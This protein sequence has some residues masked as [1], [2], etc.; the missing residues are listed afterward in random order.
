MTRACTFV[1]VRLD[2]EFSDDAGDLR[3]DAN[4]SD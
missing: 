1:L 2:A 3:A 4:G